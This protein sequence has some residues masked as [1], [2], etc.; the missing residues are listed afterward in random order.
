MTLF[1]LL[2]DPNQSPA[3]RLRKRSGLHDLD[4]I[5]DIALVHLVAC[6]ELRRTLDDFAIGGML[7]VIGDSNG[8]ALVHLVAYYLTHSGFF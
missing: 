1:R 4:G 5:S 8:D 2:D 3:D 7:Y 6:M